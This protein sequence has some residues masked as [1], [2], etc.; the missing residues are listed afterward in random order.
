MTAR[1]SQRTSET[2]HA[3]RG[4]R[5]ERADDEETEAESV[6]A[7]SDG[8]RLFSVEMVRGCR[9]HSELPA[10]LFTRQRAR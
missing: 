7:R 6:S 9:V 1:P 5:Q 8:L 4:N 10:A 2:P 3:G